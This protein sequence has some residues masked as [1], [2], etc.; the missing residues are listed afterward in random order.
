MGSFSTDSP[1]TGRRDGPKEK[2]DDYDWRS[3]KGGM[4]TLSGSNLNV[5][6]CTMRGP[7]KSETL[8]SAPRVRALA[9]EVDPSPVQYENDYDECEER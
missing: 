9:L 7:S 5:G 3:E 8:W 2:G 4:V 1:E 6:A